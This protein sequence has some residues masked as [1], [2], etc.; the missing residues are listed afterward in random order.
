MQTDAW[1][2]PLKPHEDRLVWQTLHD[3]ASALRGDPAMVVELLAV[4][5][6]EVVTGVASGCDEAQ[7]AQIAE[8]LVD[9]MLERSALIVAADAAEAMA[10]MPVCGTA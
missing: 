1:L 7:A 6:S 9:F 3:V 5:F 4:I 8:R 10:E 2:R